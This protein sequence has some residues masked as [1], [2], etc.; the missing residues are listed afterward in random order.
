M[1]LEEGS[2]LSLQSVLSYGER[3]NTVCL[4]GIEPGYGLNIFVSEMSD[5]HIQ[6]LILA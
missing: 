3:G 5:R 6:E 2:Q 4:G 1:T